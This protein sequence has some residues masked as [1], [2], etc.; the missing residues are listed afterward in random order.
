[1]TFLSGKSQAL[2]QALT[3]MQ[4]NKAALHEMR[5]ATV[6]AAAAIQP[7]V[8]AAYMFKVIAAPARDKAGV[9]SPWYTF[10]T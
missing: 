3:E 5:L 4:D 1:M 2:A 9:P 7:E 8:A 6:A 10:D